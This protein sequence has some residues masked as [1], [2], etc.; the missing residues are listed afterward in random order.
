MIGM[1]AY[2]LEI[3]LG[4]LDELAGAPVRSSNLRLLRYLDGQKL[5]RIW[6]WHCSARNSCRRPPCGT[7][8]VRKPLMSWN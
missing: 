4:I 6:T 7:D 8:T 2:Q 5:P 3:V 1:G